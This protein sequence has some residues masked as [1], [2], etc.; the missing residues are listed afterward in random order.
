M[1]SIAIPLTFQQL[2]ELANRIAT[3]YQLPGDVARLTGL[4]EK[5][6]KEILR[7]AQPK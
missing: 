4:P 5:R 6:V 3:R 7:E 2:C 1:R